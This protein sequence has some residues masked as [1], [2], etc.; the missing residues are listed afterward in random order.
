MSEESKS[1]SLQKFYLTCR[2]TNNI[3]YEN[4]LNLQY[5]DAVGEYLLKDSYSFRSLVPLSVT[6]SWSP[7]PIKCAK[8]SS[9]VYT[10]IKAKEEKVRPELL[11]SIPNDF[12]INNRNETRHSL[13]L[14]KKKI[15]KFY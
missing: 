12:K 10:A 5:T 8:I 6:K 2:I 4:R 13:F 11:F 14:Q 15:I 9:L 7:S 3:I 1:C